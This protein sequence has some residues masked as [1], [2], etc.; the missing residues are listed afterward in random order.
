MSLTFNYVYY[1]RTVTPDTLGQEVGYTWVCVNHVTVLDI[2]VNVTQ[3]LENAGYVHDKI[4]LIVRKLVFGVS[5]Q[6]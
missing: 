1:F 3:K 2:P 4:S 6:V 5:D